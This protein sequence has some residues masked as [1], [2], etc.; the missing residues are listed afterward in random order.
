[1]L[2]AVVNRDV[3]KHCD[4]NYSN[5]GRAYNEVSYTQKQRKLKELKKP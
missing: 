4:S 2:I 5:N 3:C 1:M